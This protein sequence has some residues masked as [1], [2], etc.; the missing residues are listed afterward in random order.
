MSISILFGSDR[1]NSTCQLDSSYLQGIISVADKKLY[2]VLSETELYTFKE[3]LESVIAELT[4]NFAHVLTRTKLFGKAT[5]KGREF[6][7][8]L[9][10]E[11]HLRI[12][13]LT[14]LYNFVDS[15]I[16][17]KCKL[18][19]F[20]RSYLADYSTEEILLFVAKAEVASLN[21]IRS[22]VK[23]LSDKYQDVLS[24]KPS[25]VVRSIDF[26]QKSGLIESREDGKY[27][28]TVL[29]HIYVR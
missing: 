17:Q 9:R 20:N 5:F 13:V 27:A 26:F 10:D 11:H 1:V 7:L 19:I 22:G 6:Q 16:V 29:G 15:V 2:S 25:E 18:Y 21:E 14:P 24:I 28:L 23:K 8:N 4:D 12:A 3:S